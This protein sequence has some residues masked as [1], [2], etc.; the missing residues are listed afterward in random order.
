MKGLVGKVEHHWIVGWVFD[1][2]VFEPIEIDIIYEGVLIAK[3][4][5]NFY[6]PDLLNDT[7]HID[8]K[9]GFK[10]HI[11][12]FKGQLKKLEIRANG[13]LLPF[14]KQIIRIAKRA[15]Q[16][17]FLNDKSVHFFIHI[18]KT[19]G[20]AF[21]KLLENQFEQQAIFP[22]QSDVIANNGLYPH[23]D[24]VIKYPSP[25]RKL[26][27]FVG[28][29]PFA[30]KDIFSNPVQTS[31]LLRNPVERVVSNI[32]HMKNNDPNFRDLSPAKIYKK[33]NWHFQNFQIRHLVDENISSTMRF[34]DARPLNRT[35]LDRAIER[36]K[37]CDFV[38]ISEQMDKSVALANA[39][40]GWTLEKPKQINVAK[41]PKKISLE[42]RK[43][44]KRDNHLD[45]LLYNAATTR[46]AE[47]SKQHL[48]D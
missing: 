32:F 25:N 33:G 17:L 35:D 45:I 6:R 13:Q 39:I 3:G 31:V 24:K 4:L 27:L 2:E 46:F 34:L 11:P 47:L 37:Q 20:T 43:L 8:G 16:T 42:L 1:T 7:K 21:K 19:A 29:F 14:A 9:C 22:N 28:H 12:F 23:F 5:A 44:I 10:I 15:E 18:P 26:K 40:F 48:N 38:G 30:T 41:S 36:L